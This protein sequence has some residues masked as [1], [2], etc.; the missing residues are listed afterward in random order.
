MIDSI[1]SVLSV[2]H[3]GLDNYYH[4]FIGK[5]LRKENKSNSNVKYRRDL[6][7]MVIFGH[8]MDMIGTY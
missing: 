7:A 3:I 4:L 5:E 8:K 2:V 1:K 6:E